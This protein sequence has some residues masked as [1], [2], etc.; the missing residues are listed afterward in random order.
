MS[1]DDLPSQRSLGGPPGPRQQPFGLGP[2]TLSTGLWIPLA[3]RRVA[4]ASRAF[5]CPLRNS[6]FLPKIVGP[7]GWA[8]Q[9][10]MGLPCFAPGRR[11]RRGCLLYPGVLVSRRDWF[12]VLTV[13]Y[14]HGIWTRSSPSGLTIGFRRPQ[15]TGPR[16]R[17]TGV[18][19]SDLSLARFVWM[20]QTR[21]GHYPS[22]FARAVARTLAW[23]GNRPGHW[24]GS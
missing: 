10:A 16:R 13:S 24:S 21:L 19:P 2:A 11:D 6:A 12:H 17:F 7:T 1:L 20:V 23:V 8:F 18:H 22:A 9:T 15:F 4:F 14:R 3:F 5:L